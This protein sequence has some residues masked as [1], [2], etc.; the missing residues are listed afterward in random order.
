VDQATALVHGPFK[1]PRAKSEN[2]LR[3]F[4]Q[5][6]IELFHAE[7]IKTMATLDLNLPKQ[8]IINLTN[9]TICIMRHD[10]FGSIGY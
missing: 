3:L 4:S 1:E 6:N 7:K 9:N 5:E 8:S 10:R 2:F